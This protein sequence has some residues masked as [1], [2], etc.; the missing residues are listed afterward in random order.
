MH[1]P[2]SPGPFSTLRL[3]ARGPRRRFGLLH[4][5]APLLA[6][7]DRAILTCPVRGPRPVAIAGYLVRLKGRSRVH[8]ESDLRG[9]LDWCQQR[10]LDP[11]TAARPQLRTVD[12]ERCIHHERGLSRRTGVSTGPGQNSWLRMFFVVV[13]RQRSSRL[14]PVLSRSSSR[15]APY[16]SRTMRPLSVTSKTPWSV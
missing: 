6:L 13:L 5:R 15:V 7:G 4:A 8:I 16:A 11:T 1:P 14:R 2:V 3:D 9:C 12:S 10:H